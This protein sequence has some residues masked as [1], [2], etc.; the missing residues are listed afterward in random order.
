[1][2]LAR[3]RYAFARRRFGCGPAWV[4]AAPAAPPALTLSDDAKLFATTFAGGFLFV[5]L[6]LA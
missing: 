5:S 1:M 2:Q 4:L 6:L 3:S